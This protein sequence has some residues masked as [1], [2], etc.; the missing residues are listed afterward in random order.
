MADQLLTVQDADAHNA[1]T[2]ARQATADLVLGL[3]VKEA[4][5]LIRDHRPGFAR[6]RL[7]RAGMAAERILGSGSGSW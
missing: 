4:V 6:Y 3:A 1:A 7:Q 5:D 2:K